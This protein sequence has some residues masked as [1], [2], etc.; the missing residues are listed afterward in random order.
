VEARLLAEE[1]VKLKQ[2]AKPDDKDM[3]ALSLKAPMPENNHAPLT[4]SRTPSIVGAF[5][6][7]AQRRCP[8]FVARPSGK[9]VA[10]VVVWT[11]ASVACLVGLLL[12]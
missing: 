8:R 1:E 11:V 2:V 3:P 12:T 9:F 7:T 6:E 10:A 5:R 4:R